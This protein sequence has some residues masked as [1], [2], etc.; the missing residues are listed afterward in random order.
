MVEKESG[1]GLL[2]EKHAHCLESLLGGHDIGPT[3]L[4]SRV[5]SMQDG[6]M[7]QMYPSIGPASRMVDDMDARGYHE[8]KP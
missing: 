3:S 4:G 6:Q 5:L 1:K 2:H 8:F 7:W